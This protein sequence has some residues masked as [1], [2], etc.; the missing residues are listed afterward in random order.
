MAAWFSYL[1]NG[2]GPAP[3]RINEDLFISDFS[4][5]SNKQALQAAGITHVLSAVGFE[6]P[7][8]KDFKYLILH[9]DDAPSEDLM[10]HFPKC[11]AFIEEAR[12]SGGKVLIH[13]AAGISRSSTVAIAY[14]MLSK[15][16]TVADAL[17][18]VA[19]A[20][21]I[22]CPNYGFKRQ[23]DLWHEMNY[24]LEGDSDAHKRYR[25][26]QHHRQLSRMGE[27]YPDWK[28]RAS[29]PL[30]NQAGTFSCR[31]C[32][33][34]LFHDSHC[35]VKRPEGPGSATAAPI[36]GHLV[37]PLPWIARVPVSSNQPITWRTTLDAPLPCPGCSTIVGSREY[38]HKGGL[39]WT[40]HLVLHEEA[41]AP[42]LAASSVAA[43]AS[44]L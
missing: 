44:A 8:P 1:S 43:A 18:M 42:A 22:I 6:A 35:I 9:I 14:L 24:N 21:S 17:K 39:F 3:D 32:Q 16:L 25:I 5:A 13:C 23:L 12:S 19:Q 36:K 40:P 28:P 11:I 31:K 7:H 33:H 30:P 2:N 29:D 41:V 38:D 34:P 10:Q 15:K 20:R 4:T 37:E 27:A 26:L